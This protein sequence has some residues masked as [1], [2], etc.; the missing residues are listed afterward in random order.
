MRSLRRF[1]THPF[2]RRMRVDPF[3]LR[4]SFLRKLKQMGFAG[5]QN[6]PTVGLI[7]GT[8]RENLEETGMGFGLEI[9]CIAA[10]AHELDMFSDSLRIRMRNSRVS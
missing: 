4:D 1:G 9:D 7:D 8:F 3:L 2:G 6:F 10:A 5:I